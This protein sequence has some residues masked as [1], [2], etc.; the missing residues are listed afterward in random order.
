MATS[1][2][3]NLLQQVLKVPST[4]H[5]EPHL[6]EYGAQYSWFITEFLVL[7]E[8]LNSQFFPTLYKIIVF[9]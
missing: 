5:E 2:I 1:M 4:S 6:S 8:V 7:E 3:H 9:P